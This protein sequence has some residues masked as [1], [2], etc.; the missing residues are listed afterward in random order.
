MDN[1]K[2]HNQ[3]LDFIRSDNEAEFSKAIK[4]NQNK[5]LSFGRFP[6]LSLCYIY[7]AKKITKAHQDRLI[8]INEYNKIEHE[9]LDAYNTIKD[10]AGTFLRYFQN[11][12]TISPVVV[13]AVLNRAE[14]I[15]RFGVSDEYKD[16]IAKILNAK[17]GSAYFDESGQLITPKKPLKKL[18]KIL[19]S[20]AAF[21]LAII[22]AA[23]IITVHLINQRGHGTYES[24]FRIRNLAELM[25]A[26]PQNDTYFILQSDINL[27]ASHFIDNFNANLNANNFTITASHPTPLAAR[28]TGTISN[29]TFTSH[30]ASHLIHYNAGTIS[31]INFNSGSRFARPVLS[32]NQDSS[33]I[34]DDMIGAGVITHINSGIISNINTVVYAD[35]NATFAAD[36]YD[37]FAGVITSLNRGVIDNAKVGG[38]VRLNSNGIISFMFFGGIAGKNIGTIRDSE[39]QEGVILRTSNAHTGGIVG[40]NEI[41]GNV[42]NNRMNG[43]IRAN[44]AADFMMYIG[45]V[46]GRNEGAAAGRYSVI[47]GNAVS[48]I[49]E[50]NRTGMPGGFAFLGGVT[51]L[52][53]GGVIENNAVEAIFL[54]DIER[55][56]VGG[57]YAAGV[58]KGQF[59]GRASVIQ[60]GGRWYVETVL[61]DNVYRGGQDMG[62][63][64]FAG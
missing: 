45:G 52:G 28:L 3:I 55:V 21:L 15:K 54:S 17:R 49:I 16:L 13:L 2:I 33:Q 57:Y 25:Q 6:I 12:D 42:N 31:N 18:H 32:I 14:E 36:D 50:A 26:A 60:I 19:I 61:R 56:V 47:S 37:C 1:N 30:A 43:E 58:F 46:A 11:E 59:I 5:S 24:P 23:P 41:G 62:M 7:N 22:I 4:T 29:L 40:F 51:G 64:G 39:M 44:S 63:W 48:G 34:G 27:P 20:A 35:I 8:K 9:P 38:E 10:N 53:L